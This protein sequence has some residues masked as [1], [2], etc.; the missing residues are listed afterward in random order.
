MNHLASHA[1]TRQHVD[2]LAASAPAHDWALLSRH[3]HPH[4]G[5]ADHYAA[6]LTNTDGFEVEPAAAEA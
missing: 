4:A 2:T 3:A 1:G 5:G 6:C